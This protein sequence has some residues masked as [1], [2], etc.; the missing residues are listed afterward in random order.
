M[1]KASLQEI[2]RQTNRNSCNTN[3]VAIWYEVTGIEFPIETT[4]ISTYFL[5]QIKFYD[6]N[7]I[8]EDPEKQTSRHKVAT[9]AIEKLFSVSVPEWKIYKEKK[10]THNER[11]SKQ[12]ITTNVKV[13]KQKEIELLQNCV[14]DILKKTRDPSNLKP[15]A[16]WNKA[17]ELR[18]P[19]KTVD[20]PS[21]KYLS[22]ITLYQQ[23]V[24]AEDADEQKSR[25]KV[26]ALAFEKFLNVSHPSWN[27]YK[28]PKPGATNL[29]A[30]QQPKKQELHSPKL[31]E[32]EICRKNAE[33]I[34]RRID[35]NDSNLY[36][37]SIWNISTEQK[38]K[39]ATIKTPVGTNL[40]KIKFFDEVLTA[41]DT[42]KQKSRHKVAALALDK[43]FNI[44]HRKW[45][46]YKDPIPGP[47]IS[48]QKPE[49]PKLQEQK[50]NLTPKKPL[51]EIDF[52]NEYSKR[53]RDILND[54]NSKI[55]KTN[56]VNVWLEATYQK[57][58]IITRITRRG[59][60]LSKIELFNTS[61][62]QL[63]RD[64]VNSQRKVAAIALKGFLGIVL[65][66][67]KCEDVKT[68]DVSINTGSND[69][70]DNKEKIK[71]IQM[72]RNR[73]NELL[74]RIEK[75]IE[76]TPTNFWYCITKNRHQIIPDRDSNN[77]WIAKINFFGE[78]LEQKSTFEMDS[79]H[80]VC[81]MA[82][83]KLLG[84]SLPHWK[85][86]KGQIFQ[87]I[88]SVNSEV[89]VKEKTIQKQQIP[90][91]M[92]E[93]EDTDSCD[94][95]E[96]LLNELLKNPLPEKVKLSNEQIEEILEKLSNSAR[97]IL[98]ENEGITPDEFWNLVTNNYPE[99]KIVTEFNSKSEKYE[100][101]IEFHDKTFTKADVDQHKSESMVACQA[102]DEL[103]GIEFNEGDEDS[104]SEDIV[105]GMS[106]DE[107][108]KQIQVNDDESPSSSYYVRSDFMKEPLS[109][110]IEM[111]LNLYKSENFKRTFED[112]IKSP[113]PSILRED[114][115]SLLNKIN[116]NIFKNPKRGSE[117]SSYVFVNDYQIFGSGKSEEE[118]RFAVIISAFKHIEA[119]KEG[120]VLT[121]EKETK[122]KNWIENLKELQKSLRDEK[123]CLDDIPCT[124]IFSKIGLNF[125]L[126]YSEA[127]E[128]FDP[129][130]TNIKE[131]TSRFLLKKLLDAA[132]E[133]ED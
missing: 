106:N 115:R 29:N 22:K 14:Q 102:L 64:Q 15:L 79:R 60:F 74:S 17:T 67:P 4:S 90:V 84:I 65:P 73:A 5:S 77:Q 25:H 85:S 76:S 56:P 69:K 41:E 87:K 53:A 118:A 30:L 16:V 3:P 37:L 117:F 104:L 66:Q 34:L 9:I 119:I 83:N 107:S 40:S 1:Y 59:N 68:K 108:L 39:V 120:K 48:S 57:V 12:V 43:L 131:L 55:D 127:N 28:D 116:G 36:P 72:Y 80:D 18:F 122:N 21:G 99:Y 19:V 111:L 103:L 89:T 10:P 101:T 11:D 7:F 82:C 130:L 109:I 24:T 97:E 47:K 75:L 2:L 81:E 112:F 113:M 51:L 121:K 124:E 32:I 61:F 71:A 96:G 62:T 132:Y 23:L 133:V 93:I 114:E 49:N 44:S 88:P 86:Y 13:E 105:I 27:F 38:Y 46:I 95:D 123:K 70:C 20:T 125:D 129:T 35:D 98:T 110:R 52:K 42:N 33:D 8:A 92:E 128:E 45:H 91:K 78:I 26:A 63:D 94:I 31:H 6:Q 50:L 100:S 54:S 58:P 126:G